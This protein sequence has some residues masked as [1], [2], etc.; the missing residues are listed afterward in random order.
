[1]FLGRVVEYWETE[2]NKPL[3]VEDSF[4][5]VVHGNLVAV[6]GNSQLVDE[7]APHCI[8]KLQLAE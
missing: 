5:L 2:S 3:A 8:Q 6:F 1:M 7:Q 4:E